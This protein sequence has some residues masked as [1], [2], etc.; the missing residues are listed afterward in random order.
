MK[1]MAILILMI[2]VLAGTASSQKKSTSWTEWS[3]KDVEKILNDS[4][5]GKTQVDTD[6]SEM[7]YRPTVTPN[8]SSRDV[9]IDS[10]RVERGALNQEMHVKYRIRF[11]SAKPVR[12]AFVRMVELQQEQ[13]NKQLSEQLRSFVDRDFSEYIVVAVG[14]ESTDQRLAGPVMQDINSAVASI[15]K[16]TTYL[17]RKDGKRL[18]LMDYRAPINDGMG[19]KFVFARTVDGQPFI[20]PESGEVRFYSEVGR[21]IKLNMRFKISDMMFEGRLEI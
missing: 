20:T 19:A 1:R 18:F 6:T 12:Q 15:L 13:P 4:A 3:K 17:E 14:F 8:T 9:S 2:S 10:N 7:I 21:K 16:N 11:L 5:W